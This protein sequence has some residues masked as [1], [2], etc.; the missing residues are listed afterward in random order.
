MTVQ[1]RLSR[2][3]A[4]PVASLSRALATL[5]WD[6]VAPFFLG[7]PVLARDGIDVHVVSRARD[8]ADVAHRVSAALAEI[9][10]HAPREYRR[11]KAHVRS[12]AILPMSKLGRGAHVDRG[13]RV[14]LD[15]AHVRRATA[16]ATGAVVVHEAT[17]A[18]LSARG[19]PYRAEVRERIEALCTRVAEQFREAASKGVR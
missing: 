18:F 2:G 9:E 8:A 4:R 3:V 14:Y 7:A 1:Q 19:V 11:L 12:V 10:S 6:W 17:H 16:I 15:E 13:R 5:V